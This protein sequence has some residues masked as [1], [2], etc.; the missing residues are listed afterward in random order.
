MHDVALNALI[1]NIVDGLVANREVSGT[2]QKGSM[3]WTPHLYGKLQEESA[4][5]FF[6]ANGYVEYVLSTL[7]PPHD[8]PSLSMSDVRRP[9]RTREKRPNYGKICERMK[10]KS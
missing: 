8:S 5:S 10:W 2:Y 9:G 4:L 7:P 3:I 1:P 6:K